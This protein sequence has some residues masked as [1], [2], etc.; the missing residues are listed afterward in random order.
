MVK[1]NEGD[2]F[3]SVNNYSYCDKL[4]ARFNDFLSHAKAP[5]RIFFYVWE[6]KREA[7]NGRISFGC[8]YSSEY[9]KDYIFELRRKT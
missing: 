9:M 3:L 5:V 1:P 2:N 6:A 8:D 7:I 4:W